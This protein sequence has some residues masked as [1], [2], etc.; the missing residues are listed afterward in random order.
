VTQSGHFR[1]NVALQWEKGY[2][3]PWVILR[4]YLKSTL[5]QTL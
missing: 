2:E 5:V 1:V 3:E 4:A